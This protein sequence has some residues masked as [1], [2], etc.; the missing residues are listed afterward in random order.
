MISFLSMK[1]KPYSAEKRNK[2]DNLGIWWI[3]IAIKGW[4]VGKYFFF[5][6]PMG[7][8]GIFAKTSIPTEGG[9]ES[10]EVPASF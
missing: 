9:V 5:N 7:P 8:A 4:G 1:Q 10:I 2:N 3:H 6:Q